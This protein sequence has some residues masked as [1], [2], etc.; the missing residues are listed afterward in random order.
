MLDRQLLSHF[1]HK[2]IKNRVKTRLKVIFELLS[3]NEE[4]LVLLLKITCKSCGQITLDFCLQL[5]SPFVK[6]VE[7]IIKLRLE[8]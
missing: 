6:M 3:D 1:T 2:I 8:I 5:F 4:F 7:Q